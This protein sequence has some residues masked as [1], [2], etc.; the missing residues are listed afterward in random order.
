M[1]V[2][3]GTLPKPQKY[4]CKYLKIKIAESYINDVPFA[5]QTIHQW[6]IGKL[7]CIG[8]AHLSNICIQ[9][10]DSNLC[11]ESHRAG[12]SLALKGE[13]GQHRQTH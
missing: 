11:V 5:V 13:S 12:S 8:I 1:P 2:K 9:D 7:L 10:L 6:K 4:V 3:A